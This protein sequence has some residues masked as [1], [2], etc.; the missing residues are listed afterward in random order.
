MEPDRTRKLL[1]LGAVG[2][3]I[4][5]ALT[6]VAMLLL[7]P[8]AN[9]PVAGGLGELTVQTGL[10]SDARLDPN[11]PL[12][13]FVNGQMV[14]VLLLQDCARR[15]GVPP[16]SLD[17]GLDAQGVLG[18]SNGLTSVL[19]PLPPEDENPDLTGAGGAGGDN[20]SLPSPGPT[21]EEVPQRPASAPAPAPES[22]G[23]CWRYGGSGWSRLPAE[24]PLNECVQMLFAGECEPPG[25]VAYGRWHGRTL[26]LVTGRVDI[27]A[28]NRV[29]HLVAP[30]SADCAIPPDNQ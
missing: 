25:A 13:C 18:A 15:N 24:V 12:K 23:G 19:T 27:S 26:R 2:L 8:D 16:G 5:A 17:V 11:H 3:V 1:V 21:I 14:G 20:V 7:K 4:V 29:F 22:V 30:Q 9:D 6:V 28:D 10:A